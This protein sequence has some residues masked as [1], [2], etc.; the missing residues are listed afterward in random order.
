MASKIHKF[1]YFEVIHQSE[2]DIFREITPEP[3]LVLTREKFLATEKYISTTYSANELPLE[4][5]SI[6]RPYLI[7]SGIVRIT[8]GELS[9]LFTIEL[10]H[11]SQEGLERLA[12]QL[13]LPLIK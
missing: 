6:C 1:T 8:R 13:E 5:S 3:N 11:E 2:V 7:D 9:G 10:F 4:G 12:T